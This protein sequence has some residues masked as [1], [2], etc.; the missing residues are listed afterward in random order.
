MTIRTRWCPSEIVIIYLMKPDE[1]IVVGAEIFIIRPM[2]TINS[3]IGG[4][5]VVG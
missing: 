4:Y 5:I 2:N 3:T 1:T